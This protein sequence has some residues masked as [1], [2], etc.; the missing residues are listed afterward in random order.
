[1]KKSFVYLI[2]AVMLMSVLCGCGTKTDDGVIGAT[3]MPSSNVDVSP[4]IIPDVSPSAM[5]GKDDREIVGGSNDSDTGVKGGM[6]GTEVSP[7]VGNDKS[8]K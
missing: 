5:P 7:N 6:A 3:P 8:G 4:T 1:M 2:I